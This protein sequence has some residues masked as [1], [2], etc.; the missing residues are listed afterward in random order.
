MQAFQN[1]TIWIDLVLMES[2]DE[3]PG[4]DGN[5]RYT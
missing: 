3:S 4:E 1:E 2:G 5:D